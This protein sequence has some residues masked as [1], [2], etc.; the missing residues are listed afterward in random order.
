MLDE[1]SPGQGVQSIG[2]YGDASHT[3]RYRAAIESVLAFKVMTQ[4]NGLLEKEGFLGKKHHRSL[5][6]LPILYIIPDGKNL[7]LSHF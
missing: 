1:I 3:G 5:I 6:N 7:M 2:I 4:L